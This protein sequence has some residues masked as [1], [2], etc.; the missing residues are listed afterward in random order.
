MLRLLYDKTYPLISILAIQLGKFIENTENIFIIIVISLQIII[1]ILTVW[2]LHGD[3]RNNR[4][5]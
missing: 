3:I 4:K 5:K 2:K 1:G